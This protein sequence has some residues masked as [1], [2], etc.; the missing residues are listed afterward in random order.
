MRLYLWLCEV[1]SVAVR[2]WFW[3]RYRVLCVCV[4]AQEVITR[5]LVSGGKYIARNRE[6]L[7]AAARVLS[8]GTVGASDGVWDDASAEP[9]TVQSLDAWLSPVLPLDGHGEEREEEGAPV[10]AAA[11]PPPA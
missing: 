9:T 5:M 7:L 3:M 10:T 6:A 1:V 11:V 8:P 4:W 2:G